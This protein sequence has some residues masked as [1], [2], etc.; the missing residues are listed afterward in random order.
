MKVQFV[1][2][3]KW[4]TGMQ[5]GEKI[6]NFKSTFQVIMLFHYYGIVHEI[7]LVL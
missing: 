6:E 5:L 3:A 7:H 1:K 4:C 2:M